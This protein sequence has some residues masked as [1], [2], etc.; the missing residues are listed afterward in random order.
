[1]N[2]PIV[3]NYS[4]RAIGYMASQAILSAAPASVIGVTSKGVYICN[5]QNRIIFISLE[6]YK[7]PLTV[8]LANPPEDFY[9]VISGSRAD[10]LPGRLS[11]SGANISISIDPVSTWYPKPVS[12]TYQAGREQRLARIVDLVRE[13]KPTSG[14]AS[15]LP[16]ILER[17]DNPL[18]QLPPDLDEMLI[19]VRSIH[20]AWLRR[21]TE[22]LGKAL[23]QTLGRGRGLT[24][25]GDDLVAGFLL[26]LNRWHLPPGDP[27]E[28]VKLNSALLDIAY[29]K[30]TTLS[31][32]LIEAATHG[33]A[34]ER[35]LALLDGIITGIPSEDQCAAYALSLGNSTGIDTLAGMALAV[36]V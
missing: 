1:M 5:L 7:S 2:R 11:I 36:M 15:M 20:Q 13:D 27:V 35:M 9:D 31:A 25:S 32:N 12:G 26:A 3:E 30:T 21:D 29:T 17:S 14:L 33:H 8:N 4:A 28:P 24:P 10:C 34:D 16:V 19:L 6:P 18:G 23:S 22:Q